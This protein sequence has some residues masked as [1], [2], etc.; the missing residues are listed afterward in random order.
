MTIF[1]TDEYAW[2][3]SFGLFE[4]VVEFLIEHVADQDAKAEFVTV[5]RDHH[6]SIDL[7]IVP[8]ETR[9]EILRLLREDLV[10]A[11]VSRFESDPLTRGH[12]ETLTLIARDIEE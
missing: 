10:P 12:L 9:R 7:R 8:A 2:T 4:W 11:I 3:A 6:G 1:V 5:L